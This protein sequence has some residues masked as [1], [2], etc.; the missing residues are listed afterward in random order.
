MTLLLCESSM[1]SS[2][3]IS[4]F[5]ESN[6][7]DKTMSVEQG[8]RLAEYCWPLFHFEQH[9]PII[10]NSQTKTVPRFSYLEIDGQKIALLKC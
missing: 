1:N 9:K 5:V 2:Q 4:A 3:T 7:R 6:P 8:R 10:G